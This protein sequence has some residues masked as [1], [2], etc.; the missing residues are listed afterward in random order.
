MG[1]KGAAA[2]DLDRAEADRILSALGKRVFLLHNVHDER[3][4]RVPDALDDVV[5]ARTDVA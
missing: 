3:T 1:S 2:G 5:S 4:A